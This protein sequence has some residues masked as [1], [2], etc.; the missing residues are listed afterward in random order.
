[1]ENLFCRRIVPEAPRSRSLLNAQ[2]GLAALMLLLL[3]C[4]ERRPLDHQPAAPLLFLSLSVPSGIGIDVIDMNADS[5]IH[6][7]PDAGSAG[8]INIQASPDASH[9]VTLNNNHEFTVFEIPG[10]TEIA[11]TPT[12]AVGFCISPRS[13][14][15][16]G[17][18]HDSIIVYTLPELHHDTAIE[19]AVKF[20]LAGPSDTM[21]LA[22]RQRPDTILNQFTYVISTISLINFQVSEPVRL[23]SPLTGKGIIVLEAVFSPDRQDLVLVGYDE[24]GNA[25]FSFNLSDLRPNFRTDI[26]TLASTLALSPDGTFIW[27]TQYFPPRLDPPPLSLG[28]V[29]IVD[30]QSGMVGDTIRTIGLRYGR[31]EWPLP[32][33]QIGFHPYEPKA[34]VSALSSQ[35]ALFVVDTKSHEITNMLYDD[36]RTSVHIMTIASP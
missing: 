33:F 10:R 32:V 31:P 9:L 23:R 19:L 35:P 22:F 36:V 15:V 14:R 5:V 25:A 34:Y 3:G 20:C 24:I 2:L 26:E 16:I 4:A 7:I 29:L 13:D 17:W 1:M 6:R 30:A 8:S 27:V 21:L 11:S 18:T 28:Y 12:Q